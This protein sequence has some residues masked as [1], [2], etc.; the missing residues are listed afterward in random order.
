MIELPVQV[1][2]WGS[3]AADS[4]TGTLTTDDPYITILDST[5]T[6][7]TI[8]GGSLA[9]SGEDFDFSV[10]SDCPDG[11]LLALGLTLESAGESWYSIIQLPAVAAAFDYA[12]HTSSGFGEQIDPGESGTIAVTLANHGNAAGLD[13]TATL[14]SGST[15]ID[16]TAEEGSYGTI[17]PGG[18]AAND[19][20]PFGISVAPECFGG[21]V[22]PMAL[23]VSFSGGARDTVHFTITIG[24]Q[25]ITDPT[26]PCAYGYYAFDNGDTGYTDAPAYDWVEIAPNHGGPGTSLGLSDNGYGQD[27]VVTVDLPFGFSYYGQPFTRATICSNG[28]MCMGSTWLVNYRNWNIPCAG[29][30]PNLIAPMWDNFYLSGSDAV[31]HWYDAGNHRY[32]VQ[33]SRVKNNYG[34]AVSNF[35]VIL[36][37]EAHYPTDTDDGIILFQYETFSNVD[38]GQHYS[39]IGIQDGENSTGV[40][41]GY[42]NDYNG[43]AAPITSGTAI[44]FVP[45]ANVPR[46][47]LSG[48][49]TNLTAGG[50]PLAG[51]QVRVLENGHTLYSE[52]DGTY[53][54]T[55]PTGTYTLV[56]SFEGFWPD[57]AF[58]VPIVES[59]VT[60]RN[61]ILTDIAGP[62]FSET[63][64]YG[65]TPNVTGPYVIETTVIEHSGIDE[66]SLYYRTLTTEWSTVPLM[67]QIGDLYSGEIPGQPLNSTVAYYLYGLDIGGNESYDPPGAPEDTYL[68]YVLPSLVED[69]F[70]DGMG[71][72]THEVVTDGFHDQWH[73]STRRNHSAGGET[74]W[75]FGSESSGEYMDYC[76][77]ALITP[78]FE[79]SSDAT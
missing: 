77:G 61:F 54:G 73:L 2:N 56:A 79:L 38:Y 4:V 11:H 72:W 15:W 67:H 53:E 3:V 7:G 28:W 78:A 9:W 27:D 46:G 39:T 43:G 33:W 24:S 36:Y 66:V 74:S 47:T 16:V 12:G 50:A 51:A 58:G 44:R 52:T 10:A 71:D 23:L 29:A 63:T 60:S 1:R 35:E 62:M 5:E 6:F 69:A 37:D 22:A 57:T 42:Y 41:Y 8:G 20:R 75:M 48:T 40:M 32:V 68:F 31:Y 13:V 55:V 45:V 25:T 64:Q 17:L 70:E 18:F 26:G 30:P 19:N 49:V 21:L 34:A 65:N 14:V 76:D 59:E